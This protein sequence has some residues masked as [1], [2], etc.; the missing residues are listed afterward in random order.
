MKKNQI[1]TYRGNPHVV[2]K[3]GKVGI[4]PAVP[5]G[6]H[7]SHEPE[8]FIASA[9]FE[10][11]EKA[12]RFG[13]WIATRFLTET[14]AFKTFK[15]PRTVIVETV[16]LLSTSDLIVR[17]LKSGPKRIGEISHEVGKPSAAVF[18]ILNSLTK[19]GL[20]TCSDKTYSIA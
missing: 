17:F 1:V 4:N 6:V 18:S 3:F 14:G 8:V 12:E 5:D 2:L 16:P 10:D 13:H 9:A 11:E 15:K 7:Y 19:K 20:V